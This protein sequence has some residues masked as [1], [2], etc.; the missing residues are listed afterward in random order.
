MG[1]QPLSVTQS[2]L[3]DEASAAR[4]RSFWFLVLESA[5]PSAGSARWA[6]SEL[7]ELRLGRGPE[8]AATPQSDRAA[9]QLRVSAPDP[10]MSTTHARLARL[11][12]HWILQDSGSK[13]GT[14]VNGAEVERHTLAPGDVVETGGTFWAY[15]EDPIANPS[16]DYDSGSLPAP[17]PGLGS[18]IPSLA[19]QF[20]RL[21]AVARSDVSLLVQGATG[22]GK[23]LVARAVHETSARSGRFV[24]VNCGALPHTLVE[25]E[26]F[27]HRRGAFS[28]ATE[29][30]PGWVRSADHGTL[31]LDEV[32]DLPL[33][34]QAALLRVLQEREVVPVGGTQPIR[35]DVRIIAATHRNLEQMVE[36]GRFRADLLAR[37]RGFALE[38]PPLAARRAE[39]GHLI[40]ALCRRLAPD[41]A[42]RLELSQA[43]ARTLV[44]HEWPLNV[45]ELEQALAAALA[46][47]T[48]PAHRI[49]LEHLPESIRARPP[50]RPKPP[51]E[52]SAEDLALKERVAALLAEHDG[53][54]SAVA[55]ALGKDRKQVRRWIAR[56]RLR[57]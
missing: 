29:D 32:G 4:G 20:E 48:P 50:A 40:A 46:L 18:L 52:L 11:G 28:G 44:E 27:G 2:V 41:R 49:E 42:A 12:G 15:L 23:E 1:R 37:L 45:R 31:L 36:E 7:D 53:N 8:R 54:L 34:S 13:N 3:D 9:R 14:R 35:V 5:R 17:A 25:A 30:R 39:L 21:L 55:R 6:L 22:T 19:R 10:R 43:A 57:T 56:F 47:V 16:E 24:A 26:L 38:I 51:A 33:A